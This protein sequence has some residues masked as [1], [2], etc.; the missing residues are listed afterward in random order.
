MTDTMTQS[1]VDSKAFVENDQI[2]RRE[3]ILQLNQS[4]I[5]ELN[6]ENTTR[7]MNFGSGS[8]QTP[9]RLVRLSSTTLI[10]PLPSRSINRIEGNKYKKICR[11]EYQLSDTDQQEGCY[12]KESLSIPSIKSKKEKDN[13][14]PSKKSSFGLQPRTER[15][16]NSPP[17]FRPK[18]V[19]QGSTPYFC[20]RYSS[21]TIGLDMKANVFYLNAMPHKHLISI[22]VLKSKKR[23]KR[24]GLLKRS[25]VE[26]QPRKSTSMATYHVSG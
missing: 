18:F 10:S 14:C 15:G 7:T 16:F 5:N 22:P 23:V 4:E 9:L 19:R 11:E 26:L 24:T 20:S 12:Y 3:F 8:Y 25:L 21:T 6:Y 13:N 2:H 1:N 17:R